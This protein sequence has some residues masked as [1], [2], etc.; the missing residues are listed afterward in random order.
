MHARKAEKWSSVSKVS[1]FVWLLLIFIDPFL[2]PL[3][4]FAQDLRKEAI[5]AERSPPDWVE[6]PATGAPGKMQ[7]RG[8]NSLPTVK[9]DF[10]LEADSVLLVVHPSTEYDTKAISE[11]GLERWVRSAKAA[12][13][14]IVY[15]VDAPV[16]SY[17][18]SLDPESS[19]WVPFRHMGPLELVDHFIF[20]KGDFGAEISL[21]AKTYFL[22]GGRIDACQ[23]YAATAFFAQIKPEFRDASF[24][25][26]QSASY[27]GREEK[28]PTKED[29]EKIQC[30]GEQPF[31]RVLNTGPVH[32]RDIMLNGHI[33]KSLD[34]VP[35]EPTRQHPNPPIVPQD[36]RHPPRIQLGLW[37]DEKN[38]PVEFRASSAR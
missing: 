21:K 35:F 2:A 36:L 23:S 24:I 11:P 12:K 31:P 22:A 16:A 7:S 8:W 14:P 30:L 1:T 28:D 4:V 19:P 34:A 18:K 27:I 10:K 38:P 33:V 29:M 13:I 5:V 6:K 9:A 17:E 37:T 3:R 15:V 26:L 25:L 20:D 32:M